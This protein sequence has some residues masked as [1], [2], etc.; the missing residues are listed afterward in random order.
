MVDYACGL[1]I[2]AAGSPR[3]RSWWLAASVCTNLG[4]LGFF[5]YAGFFAA[6]LERASGVELNPLFAE[7][8]LPVGI[9]F[10][11]FQTMSYTI[12]V[13]RRELEPTRD[14]LNFA[15]FVAFFPQLVAGPIERARVLLPQIARPRVVTDDDLR[16]GLHLVL[17][18]YL[19]KLVVA[20]NMAPLTRE[21]FTHPDQH[22]GSE[23]VVAAWA[24]ALQI[25]GDFAGYSRIARGL[26]RWMGIDLMVNFA[27]PYLATNPS[28]FW[29]R[30]HVSLSTWLRDYLYIP[31]GGNRGGSFRTYRNLALTMLLGGLWHGAAWTFLL[32]GAFHGGLLIAHRLFV[33][34][35]GRRGLLRAHAAPL[36]L[37][38]RLLWAAVFLQITCVGWLIF[39]AQRLAHLP[40]M[41]RRFLADPLH[42]DPATLLPVAVVGAGVLFCDVVAEAGWK[43]DLRGTRPARLAGYAAGSFLLTFLGV[44]DSHEFIYF[45][46]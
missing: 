43:A 7:I 34:W 1:R 39:F 31:L 17:T 3:G 19:L 21:F 9:S 11:T 44:F 8:V 27:R 35:R 30:W 13:Y 2:A 41:A 25:Y 5:K 36:P 46:F 16:A 23:V 22:R 12:D 18:G 40:A 10:Y 45:Q 20:E 28:D 29:R 37:G 42:V 6:S 26:A 14:F 32:W 33:G 15:V 24:A 38:R 4:V